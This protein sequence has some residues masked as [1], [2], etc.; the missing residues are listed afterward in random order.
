MNEMIERVAR[1]IDPLIWKLADKQPEYRDRDANKIRESLQSARAAIKAM[2]EPTEAMV[3]VGCEEL[4]WGDEHGSV[5]SE[6]DAQWRREALMP[7]WDGMLNE[8]LK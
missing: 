8:A 6:L 1:A 4:P 3:A 7:I 5:V 2:R